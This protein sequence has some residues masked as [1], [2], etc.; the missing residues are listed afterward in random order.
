MCIVAF[1]CGDYMKMGESQN[2]PYASSQAA[3]ELLVISMYAKSIMSMD[4][5]HYHPSTT[6][7]G[8]DLDWFCIG[9]NPLDILSEISS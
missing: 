1:V 5:H 8:L 3:V 9:F 2:I 6:F 4:E 7:I